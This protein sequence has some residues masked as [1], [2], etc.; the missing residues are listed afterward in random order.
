[1]KKSKRVFALILCA[2][3]LSSGVLSG[4]SDKQDDVTDETTA[5]DTTTADTTT[6]EEKLVAN[7]PDVNMDGYTF[8]VYSNATSGNCDNFPEEEIGEEINDAMYQRNE[9]LQDRYNFTLMIESERTDNNLVSNALKTNSLAGDA[10]IQLYLAYTT[11]VVD[12]FSYLTPIDHLTYV[13]YSMPWWFPEA[14]EVFQ[15]DGVQLALSGCFD[16]AMPSKAECIGF[17]KELIEELNLDYDLY[18]LAREGKWTLDKLAEVS[19]LGARDLDGDGDRDENDRFGIRGHWKA[20][21]SGLINGMGVSFAQKDENGYPV[22]QGGSD[23]QLVNAIQTMQTLMTNHPNLYYNTSEKPWNYYGPEFDSG[24]TIFVC[25]EISGVAGSLRDLDFE[26]GVLPIPKADEEQDQYYCQTAYG[27][28]PCV[29][30]SLPAEQYDYVGILLEAF[31]FNTYDELLPI[32]KEKTLKSK[33]ASDRESADMIDIVWDSVFYDFGVI[34]WEEKLSNLV[35]E[36]LLIKDGDNIVSY[37]TSLE[38]NLQKQTENIR[39]AIA[40]IK[41]AE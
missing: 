5:S 31:A 22:F 35:V 25:T 24:N 32:Y 33:S 14:S 26:I 40:V 2:L 11:K 29:A 3:M 8:N 21:G 41:S 4:C 18:D 16:L 27:H 30:S 36:E 7:L 20:F 10:S 9:I 1:M 17:N 12:C 38:P 13:D 15:I 39:E 19:T 28:S 34:C 37:L 6:A 23:E